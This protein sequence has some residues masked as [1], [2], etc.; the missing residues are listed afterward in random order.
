[1]SGRAIRQAVVEAIQERLSLNDH[2]VGLQP[3]GRPPHTAGM[4]YVAVHAGSWRELSSFD[5][6]YADHQ[7]A[8]NVTI[9]VR[10]GHVPEDRW[11]RETLNTVED[12]LEKWAEEILAAVHNQHS[13]M[14]DANTILESATDEFG[15]PLRFTGAGEPQE[16]PPSWWG[17]GLEHQHTQSRQPHPSKILGFSQTLTFDGARRT[18]LTSEQGWP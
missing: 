10:A 5:G 2:E 16:R 18:R 13:V 3:A 6:H 7:H 14:N 11:G 4:I 9:S 15:E 17:A 8:V 1:M 12:G